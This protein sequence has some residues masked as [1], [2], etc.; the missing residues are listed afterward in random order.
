MTIVT[1]KHRELLIELLMYYLANSRLGLKEE[2]FTPIIEN[3]RKQNMAG[4]WWIKEF[5]DNTK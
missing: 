2:S 1:G 3:I 4:D 5:I